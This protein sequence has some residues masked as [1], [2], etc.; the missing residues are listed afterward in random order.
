MPLHPHN[1]AL[2]VWLELG[3]PGAALFAAFIIL[4]WRAV[5]NASWPPLFKAAAGGSLLMTF[6]A[7]FGTYGIWQEWWIATMWLALFLILL[8]ARLVTGE[9]ATNAELS[10]AELSPSP[11]PRAVR[12]HM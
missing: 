6:V 12:S 4:L 10:D 3:L 11:A 2:Q 5:A 9:R 1:S 8:M 7:S